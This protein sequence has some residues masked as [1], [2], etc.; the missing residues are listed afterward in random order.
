MRIEEGRRLPHTSMK[1]YAYY[2]F[3]KYAK[4]WESLQ[5]RKAEGEATRGEPED[6]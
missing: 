5:E 2:T 6:S 3:E 1:P 4:L